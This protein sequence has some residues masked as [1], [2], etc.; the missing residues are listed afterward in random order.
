MQRPRIYKTEAVILK[1]APIGEADRILTLFTASL[2]KIKAVAKGV[3]RPKSRIGGHLEP[4]SHCR[5]MLARGRSLDIISS[6]ETIHSFPK[7]KEQLEG[8]ARALICL[9]LVDAFTAEEQPNIGILHLLIESLEWLESGEQDLVIR[10]FEFHLLQ[11]LGYMPELHYCVICRS[12]IAPNRHAFSSSMGGTICFSC[13]H[14]QEST[15][16]WDSV[17]NPTFPIS[18]NTLKV[19][20]FIQKTPYKELRALHLDNRV[21]GELERLTHRYISYLLERQIKSPKFLDKLKQPHIN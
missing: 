2:G 6:A 13:L 3:R 18:L 4:L 12:A 17:R 15:V 1:Q 9:E 14:S 5:L 16:L 8:I 19:L 7:V 21:A 11:Q 20:R 10:F